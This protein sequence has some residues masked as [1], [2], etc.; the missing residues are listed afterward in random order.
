MKLRLLNGSHSSIAYLGQLGGWAT[1]AEAVADPSVRHHITALTAE[2][3]GTLRLPAAVDLAAYREALLARFSNPELHH[4]TTQIAMDGSQKLPQR[5]FAP[6]LNLMQ[7]GRGAPRIALGVAA[8]LRFLRGQ[9]DDGTSLVLDDPKSERLRDAARAASGSRSL[10]DAVFAMADI[11]PPALAASA[12]FGD[13]VLAAL[14]D[15][16]SHGVRRTLAI[17]RD[18]AATE[19]PW[20]ETEQ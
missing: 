8:W 19:G 17:W 9:A 3:S 20:E 14:E 2:I 11:V 4:R 1:V 7:A 15:L 10:R 12:Y 18:R 16:A 5:L 13:A 6:A